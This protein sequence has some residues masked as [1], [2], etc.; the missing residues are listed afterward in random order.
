MEQSNRKIDPDLLC[1][2]FFSIL[3]NGKGYQRLVRVLT[4]LEHLQSAPGLNSGEWNSHAL[5]GKKSSNNASI[6]NNLNGSNASMNNGNGNGNGDVRAK[7]NLSNFR[8]PENGHDARIETHIS[9]DGIVDEE[10]G[11]NDTH[12]NRDGAKIDRSDHSNDNAKTAESSK[13]NALLLP[14]DEELLFI[15][16]IL[17]ARNLCDYVAGFKAPGLCTMGN[18]LEALEKKGDFSA[19]LKPRCAE[20]IVFFVLFAF[21]LVVIYL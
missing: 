17:T 14:R 19:V 11:N 20:F 2:I 1:Q 18:I 6:D 4:L 12:E 10:N 15:A 8:S 21:L 16:N 7:Y 3:A 5:N 9:E 13:M